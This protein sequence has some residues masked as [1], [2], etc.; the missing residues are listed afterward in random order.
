M[1]NSKRLDLIRRLAKNADHPEIRRGVDGVAEGRRRERAAP[2]TSIPLELVNETVE[3][4]VDV[5]ALHD[6]LARLLVRYHRNSVA[7]APES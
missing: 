3:E 1:T 2:T 7:E 6:V 5:E 4:Q